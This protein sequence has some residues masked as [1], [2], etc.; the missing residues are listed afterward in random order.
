MSHIS[1]H[2]VLTKTVLDSKADIPLTNGDYLDFVATLMD[3][4]TVLAELSI[5]PIFAT[6]TQLDLIAIGEDLITHVTDISALV[7]AQLVE[8][9]ED[10][11][12]KTAIKESLSMLGRAGERVSNF[13]DLRRSGKLN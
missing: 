9:M 1:F 5:M 7:M 6:Q 10:G 4:G 13:V 8:T 3:A 2:D 12:S 11:D